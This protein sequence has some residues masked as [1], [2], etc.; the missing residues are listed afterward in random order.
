MKTAT[1]NTWTRDNVEV[2]LY[3]CGV[4]FSLHGTKY[5][6][7]LSARYVDEDNEAEIM[8]SWRCFSEHDDAHPTCKVTRTTGSTLASLNGVMA[9]DDWEGGPSGVVREGGPEADPRVVAAQVLA[10]IV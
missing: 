4:R 2:R 8:E 10:E 9:F 1:F 3:D 5:E 7:V 6:L